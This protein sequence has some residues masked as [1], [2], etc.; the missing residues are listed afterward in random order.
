VRLDFVTE[1]T[2]SV[3]PEP[4]GSSPWLQEPATGPYPKPTES[5]LPPPKPVSLTKIHFDPILSPMPYSSR[6]LSQNRVHFSVLSHACH[7]PVDL[8]SPWLDLSN[9]IWGR[10]R[11]MKLLTV[12]IHSSVT[13]SLLGQIFS[14]EPCLTYLQSHVNKI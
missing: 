1:L 5:T 6:A 10:V 12:Q 3:A 11:I 2:N 7:M 14:L 13:L 8:N 4:E 9:D